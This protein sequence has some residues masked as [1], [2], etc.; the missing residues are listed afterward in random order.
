MDEFL[1]VVCEYFGENWLFYNRTELYHC[2]LYVYI[3]QF[4]VQ[5]SLHASGYCWPFSAETGIRADSRFAP[6]QWETALLCNNASHWLDTNLESALGIFWENL[7]N[8]MAADG[9][10]SCVTRSSPA[11]VLDMQYKWILVCQEEGFQL[12]VPYQSYK[13]IEKGNIYIFP[14]IISAQEG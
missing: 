1:L 5:Y 12:P 11:M 7:I 3:V 8:T 10:V 14:R 13:F 2:Y 6:S 9:L 4:I